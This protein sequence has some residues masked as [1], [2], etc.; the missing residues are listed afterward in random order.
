MPGIIN[1]AIIA[2]TMSIDDFIISYFNKG[3]GVTTLAV[4][5]Y[6]MVKKPITPEINAL[7]T[8]MF[9]SILLLLV[10]INFR[11]GKQEA[12]LSRRKNYNYQQL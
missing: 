5:I 12:A 1:G 4:E 8:L 10:V 11:Q 3:P 7:F 2:F 9:I 6:T